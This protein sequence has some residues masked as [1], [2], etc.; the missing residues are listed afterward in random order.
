[1][2][3]VMEKQMREANVLV[4]TAF[5]G[6]IPEIMASTNQ[7]RQ[8]ML[9]LIKNGKESM[10]SGGTLN[11]RTMLSGGN[12]L[13]I[14]RDTG[15]GIPE[16][17]RDKIFDAFFTTKQKVKGVGLGLSVCYGIIK[18][19]GGEIKVESEVGKGATFIISLPA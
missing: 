10:P 5:S 13:I 19:H 11:V 9:N 7:I 18:D 3:L 1:I 12:V 17:I 16:E 14:V 15:A 4:T 6:E 8:V 2:L